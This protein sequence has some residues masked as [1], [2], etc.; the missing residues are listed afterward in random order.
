M[1]EPSNGFGS[2]SGTTHWRKKSNLRIFMKMI[3]DKSA[4]YGLKKK[5]NA[6][7]TNV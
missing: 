4:D 2:M 7:R 6:E 3:A 5:R 1:K